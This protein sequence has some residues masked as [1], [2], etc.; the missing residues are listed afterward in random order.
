MIEFNTLHLL[1][2]L[3]FG[4][5]GGLI[6]SILG[7]KKSIDD[8]KVKKLTDVDIVILITTFVLSALSGAVYYF[9]RGFDPIEI[10]TIGFIGDDAIKGLLKLK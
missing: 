5:W 9:I 2:A 3:L 1:Y 6:R 10:I 7:I 8:G 4:T